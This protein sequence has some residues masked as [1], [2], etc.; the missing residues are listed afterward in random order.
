MNEDSTR[1]KPNVYKK[2][3]VFMQIVR[4]KEKETEN[5]NNKCAHALL[6][7]ILLIE[8]KPPKMNLQEAVDQGLENQTYVPQ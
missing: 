5:K 8:Q 4:I 1:I 7:Y 3:K 6:N 2:K